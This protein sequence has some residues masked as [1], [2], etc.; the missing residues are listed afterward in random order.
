MKLEYSSEEQ[1]PR[2]VP[3]KKCSKNM[4][5]IYRETPMPKCDLN[6]VS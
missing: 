2:G 5:Q 3:R 1:P 6:K 4:Q